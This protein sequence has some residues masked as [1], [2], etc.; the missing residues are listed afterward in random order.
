MATKAKSHDYRPGTL[1]W[2][3]TDAG[4]LPAEREKQHPLWEKD[5]Q[6]IEAY[7]AWTIE[8]RRIWRETRINK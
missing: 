8:L 1:G 4:W 7:A 6:K 2:C 3:L 5:G